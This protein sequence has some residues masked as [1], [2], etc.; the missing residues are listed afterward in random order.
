MTELRF[1]S[2]KRELFCH[3]VDENLHGGSSHV[4]RIRLEL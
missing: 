4:I 3:D 2:G 1:A